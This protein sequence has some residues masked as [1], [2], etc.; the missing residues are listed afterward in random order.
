M[1]LKRMFPLGTVKQR[2][3]HT[4]SKCSLSVNKGL[5][6]PCTDTPNGRHKRGSLPSPTHNVSLPVKPWPW[7]WVMGTIVQGYGLQF[8][9]CPPLF[10][11]IMSK[12]QP[13]STPVLKEEIHS[14]LQK[15]AIRVVPPHDAQCGFYSRYFVI[16]KKDGFVSRVT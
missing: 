1:P 7:P 8:S 3:L 5:F 9:K 12:V 6:T 16:P 2:H 15:R 10:R 4:C 11:G 13:S 14:L